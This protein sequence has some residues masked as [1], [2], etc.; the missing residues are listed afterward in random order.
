M[1]PTER[2][3]AIGLN[4]QPC[5]P[6]KLALA[7]TIA[8]ATADSS[9]LSDAPD[10]QQVYSL[11]ESASVIIA[12]Q[13][14]SEENP[15]NREENCL[16]VVICG[17]AVCKMLFALTPLRAGRAFL[18]LENIAELKLN[19]MVRHFLN[20]PG[21]A[22]PHWWYWDFEIA[23]MIISGIGSLADYDQCN[24]RRR[25]LFDA[26]QTLTAATMP[27]TVNGQLHARP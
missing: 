15:T 23:K 26:G 1:R 8:K 24:A 13:L 20:C 16:S 4:P 7:G 27:C 19:P 25:E 22:E 5:S 21:A 11:F 2:R 10:T 12:S 18:L 17:L 14:R 6:R 9:L 3:A